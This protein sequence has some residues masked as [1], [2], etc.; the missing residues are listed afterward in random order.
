MTSNS[1]SNMPIFNFANVGN[2]NG[3]SN[4]NSSN[5]NTTLPMDMSNNNANKRVRSG[6]EDNLFTSLNNNQMPNTATRFMNPNAGSIINMSS[7]GLSKVLSNNPSI[8]DVT[9]SMDTLNINQVDQKNILQTMAINKILQNKKE[10]KQKMAV[11]EKEEMKEINKTKKQLEDRTLKILLVCAEKLNRPN[12]QLKPF[13]DSDTA[14]AI[15]FDEAKKSAVNEKYITDFLTEYILIKKIQMINREH[16]E[17]CVKQMYSEDN[18]FRY[19][20]KPTNKP[21]LKIITADKIN[22]EFLHSMEDAEK[23]LTDYGINI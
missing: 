22:P 6:V 11:K 13:K 1:S 4:S 17:E 12:L 10:E 8:D 18:R 7:N 19:G 5:N 21:K 2:F 20:R 23:M 16:V 3:D 14:F 15:D 9:L